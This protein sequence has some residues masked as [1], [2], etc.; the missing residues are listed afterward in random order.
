MGSLP[1]SKYDAT[2]YISP[3]PVMFMM[4]LIVNDCLMIVSGGNFMIGL[5]LSIYPL[6]LEKFN[7][8]YS[9]LEF[10]DKLL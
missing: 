7:I 10:I 6:I 8:I 4:F 9:T 1:H 3:L 5:F 2:L